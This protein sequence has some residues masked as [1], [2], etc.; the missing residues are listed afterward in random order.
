[1]NENPTDSIIWFIY[2]CLLYIGKNIN[3]MKQFDL[4][5]GL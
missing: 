2:L 1:M 4:A 5:F 3:A